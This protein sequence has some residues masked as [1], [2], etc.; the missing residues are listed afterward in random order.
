MNLVNSLEKGLALLKVAVEERKGDETGVIDTSVVRDLITLRRSVVC[1]EEKVGRGQS[2]YP[3]QRTM[4]HMY[5][6]LAC[7][8]FPSSE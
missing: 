6:V 5:D 4:A 8:P 1:E 2:R 3:S 7:F